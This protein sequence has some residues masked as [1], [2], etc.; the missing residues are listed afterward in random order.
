MW[1]MVKHLSLSIGR[2]EMQ[3]VNA[4]ANAIDPSAISSN[5]SMTNAVFVLR[6]KLLV[7]RCLPLLREP[8]PFQVWTLARHFDSVNVP[9]IVLSLWLD[10]YF[11]LG[12]E[13]ESLWYYPKIQHENVLKF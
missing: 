1:V 11:I 5:C 3:F 4:I 2:A 7:R 12:P 6:V 13:F 8:T 10:L 9:L